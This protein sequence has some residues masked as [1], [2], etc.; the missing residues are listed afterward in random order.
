M[1]GHS[2]EAPRISKPALDW[3]TRYTRVYLRRNFHAVRLLKATLP[4]AVERRPLIVVMNHPGWWDPLIGVLLAREVFP[5]RVHYAPMD[6][7]GLEKYRFFEKLG[8]FGIDSG[9]LKGAARFLHVASTVL[10]NPES[11]LWVTAQGAFADVRKRPVALRAGVGH[12]VCRLRR[13][14]V[15]P[16]AIEYVFWEERYPEALVAFGDPILIDD[17]EGRMAREWTAEFAQ[18]LEAAQDRL[19]VESI[20]RQADRFDVLIGGRTGVGGVYDAWR[21]LQSRLR[22]ERFTSAHGAE[23]L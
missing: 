10:A 21:S 20:A 6:G 12:L 22:G 8:L 23:K 4:Q 15:I 9:T 19:A 14:A 17:G 16:L 5:R 11:A 1:A 13:V 3:F 7:R 18:A 2:V